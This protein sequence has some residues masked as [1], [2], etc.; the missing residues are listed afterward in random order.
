M[1]FI[2]SKCSFFGSYDHFFYNENLDETTEPYPLNNSLNLSTYYDLKW[3]SAGFDYGFLFGSETAHRI[4]PNIS[5]LFRFKDIGFIDRITIMP[6]ISGIWGNQ[7]ILISNP[8]YQL[9]KQL[10]QRI[11]LRK[12]RILY[13]NRPEVVEGLVLND[14][15]EQDSF[16]LMNYSINLPVYV[17]IGKLGISASYSLNF[18]VALPGEELDLSTNSYFGVSA[19]YTL[20]FK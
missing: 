2:N 7:T 13:Q 19:S 12:F 14:Y 3:V 8:N 20:Y 10:I 16:G 1:G 15:T 11:G 17:Y 4:R 18:P 6:G 5:G 9:V